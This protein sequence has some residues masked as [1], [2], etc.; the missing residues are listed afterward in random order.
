MRTVQCK[1]A[2]YGCGT[3]GAGVA[4]ALV[5]RGAPADR[6]GD[7]IALKYIVDARLDE[8]RRSLPLPE[9][10]I[11]TDDLDEAL[12]DP[13][14]GV[15]VE[16][17]GGTTV[18]RQV[19]ASALKAGKD[20]VT[21]NKALLAEHGDSLYRLARRHGRCIAFE[22]SVGGGIP[23]IAAVRDGLVGDRIESVYGI[24]NGTC[25]YVLTRMLAS[26][27]PYA[28]ALKEAQEKGYAEADPRLDVEGI[29]SAHK[30]AVLARLAFGV[31]VKLR[32]IPCE[33]I[34]GIEL[35]D[36]QYA[37]ALGCTL[38]LLAVGIRHEERLELRVQPAL[39]RQG[40][41]LARMG[42]VYNAICIHGSLAGEIVLT[43]QGAGRLPTTSA[44][45][46]D[47]VR[48]ALGV[49]GMQF[50]ALSQFG[51]VPDA[52]L[53][54]MGHVEARYYF[55][56]DCR[57]RPGVLA[58]VAGILGEEDIS[59]AS[60]RQQELASPGEKFV[61]VVFMTHPAREAS[62]KK[63]LERINAVDVVRGERTRMLRVEDV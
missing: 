22:G 9:H 44:V 61:P 56:L 63:A 35:R 60:V 31:N 28:R 47:I 43:G 30:L 4:E 14:V 19:V 59:I 55:R 13:E 6:A 45:L 16:L 21:A 20:V 12:R 23:V 7:G 25:N 2:L 11:L 33:G 8:I 54:P 42:G 34:A 17:F 40:H 18:A 37:Q 27:M 15:V 51:D 52:S 48:V 41:P 24:V 38:K 36:V 3:V 62:L 39:L 58:K 1:V 46:A 53:V 26:G 32:D 5:S 57:D 10:V 29:D 50:A 49:Y